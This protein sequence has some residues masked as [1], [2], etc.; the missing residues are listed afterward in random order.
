MPNEKLEFLYKQRERSERH[1]QAAMA[2]ISEK[3]QIRSREK[4]KKEEEAVRLKKEIRDAWN[5]KMIKKKKRQKMDRFS[6]WMDKYG[7]QYKMKNEPKEEISPKEISQFGEERILFQ[8]V[9]EK[10][11]RANFCEFAKSNE[12]LSEIKVEHRPIKKELEQLEELSEFDEDR[13]LFQAVFEKEER[14]DFFE[15]VKSS[16]LISEIEVEHNPVKKEVEQ[17]EE[18]GEF[19]ETFPTLVCGTFSTKRVYRVFKRRRNEEI[20]DGKTFGHE[21]VSQYSIHQDHDYCYNGGADIDPLEIDNTEISSFVPPDI[22]I[23]E[24]NFDF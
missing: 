4:R 3:R 19:V 16:E 6:E 17:L 14:A 15:V 9:L 11:Q 24:E 5:E 2:V 18:V 22:D 20:T 21:S 13:N 10:D 1:I 8:A 23:K 12:L 7:W